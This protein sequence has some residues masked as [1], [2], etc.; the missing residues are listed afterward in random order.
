MLPRPVEMPRRGF[1]V[2]IATSG[3][4]LATTSFGL[5]PRNCAATP[6]VAPTV[7]VTRS[8]ALS[9]VTEQRHSAKTRAAGNH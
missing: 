5:R 3:Y 1:P 7:L 2:Y 4:A 8:S 9:G 6:W